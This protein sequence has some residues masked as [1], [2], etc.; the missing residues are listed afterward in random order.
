LRHRLGTGQDQSS[1]VDAIAKHSVAVAS[2]GRYHVDRSLKTSRLSPAFGFPASPFLPTPGFPSG[3]VFSPVLGSDFSV[4]SRFDFLRFFFPCRFRFSRFS[5]GSVCTRFPPRPVFPVR[6]S[7]LSLPQQAGATPTGRW[8]QL[9]DYRAGR[10]AVGR[11]PASWS[12]HHHSVCPHYLG[13]AIY[14][15]P[16]TALTSWQDTTPATVRRRRR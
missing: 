9:V 1:P 12:C 8:R 10:P 13:S 11:A 4:F 5:S 16:I 2:F 15:L 14:P 7:P 6:F 3:P